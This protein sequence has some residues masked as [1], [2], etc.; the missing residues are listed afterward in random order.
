MART[1]KQIHFVSRYDDRYNR[2]YTDLGDGLFSTEAWAVSGAAAQ[3]VKEVWLH[4]RKDDTAWRGGNVVGREPVTVTG[5][6]RSNRWRF[7]VRAVPTSGVQWPGGTGG[8]PE[9]AYV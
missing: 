3:S 1:P 7:I 2:G 9:K 6:I 5:K 4:D 8:G